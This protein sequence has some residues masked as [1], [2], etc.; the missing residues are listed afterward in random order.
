MARCTSYKT[1]LKDYSTLE[2]GKNRARIG[3]LFMATFQPVQ[4]LVR[5]GSSFL[6][7]W[8]NLS[9]Y[10][11]QL[12]FRRL[13]LKQPANQNGN[14]HSHSTRTSLLMPLLDVDALTA[15]VVAASPAADAAAAFLWIVRREREGR[16]GGEQAW[17]RFSRI[18]VFGVSVFFRIF[19]DR[20]V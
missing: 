12:V 14:Q 1:S 5:L 2:P 15:A 10:K 20:K 4:I 13:V 11:P 3:P 9:E 18:F 7:G 16:R 8:L 17:R 6:H 19:C